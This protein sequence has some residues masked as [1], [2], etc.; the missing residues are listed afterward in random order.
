M[1]LTLIFFTWPKSCNDRFCKDWF[2]IYNRSHI[3]FTDKKFLFSME[4]NK[5]SAQSPIYV[6]IL[7]HLLVLKCVASWTI[8]VSVKNWWYWWYLRAHFKLKKHKTTRK[9]TIP[10]DC[11][12]TTNIYNKHSKQ[13]CTNKPTNKKENFTHRLH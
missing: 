7:I 1:K 8:L 13:N 3:I 6:H 10:V 4:G 5:D 2:I 12:A 11:N 9:F